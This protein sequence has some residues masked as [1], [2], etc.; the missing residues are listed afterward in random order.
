VGEEREG[1]GDEEEGEELSLPI[2]LVLPG[3][4]RVRSADADTRELESVRAS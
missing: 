3:R 4:E 1:R 2:E